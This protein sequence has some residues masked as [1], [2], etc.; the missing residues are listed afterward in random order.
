MKK[1]LLLIIPILAFSKP[2]KIDE[3][4][5]EKNSFRL[6][7]SIS[8]SNIQRTDGVIAPFEYETQNGDFVTIPTFFGQSRS[9]QDYLNYGL[10]L[11]YGVSRDIELF[12]SLNLYTADTHYSNNSNFSTKHNK[13][14]NSFSLGATYQV[15][16]ENERPSLL[17]GTTVDAIDRT[18][19][20]N[21]NKSMKF[22]GY[23]FFATSYYTVDPIVFLLRSAYRLNLKKEHKQESIES[24][25]QFSL[26]PQLYF[27]M[28]PYTSL[29]TGVRYSYRSQ[30]K[31]D[32]EAV[33][34]SGSSLTYLLGT[35]YEINAKSTLNIDVDYSDSMGVSQNSLSLGLSYKF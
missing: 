21:H 6:D 22:K 27:A 18:A 3:I 10:T 9:N 28:N 13:G 17:L 26:S 34:S 23:T 25:D 8:Y 30:T 32:G 4:L 16:H 2:V 24:A 12:S 33:S 1:T 35:S 11:R 20:S 5:T 14:F 19:F 7:T 15:K 31:I 29:S